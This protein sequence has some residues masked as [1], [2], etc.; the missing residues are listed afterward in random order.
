MV[1]EEKNKIQ[2][3]TESLRILA[4]GTVLRE[5]LE[6]ILRAKTGALIVVGDN[7]EVIDLVNGG[8]YINAELTSAHLYELAKM[9]GAIILSSDQRKILYANTQL[10]PDPSIPS[11]ETGIR[12]RIAQRV[13]TQTSNL[14]ISISQRR[15]IITLYKGT[16]KYILQDTN[17]VLNK[18]NQAIQ[19]LEKYKSVLDQAMTS[20]SALELE[21]LVTLYDVCLVIQRTEMVIRITSEIEKYIN[22]LGSEG[23]LVSMQLEE[24]ICFVKE[25]G[26]YVIEDYRIDSEEKSKESIINRLRELSSEELLDLTNIA[27][28]LGYSYDIN[29]LDI[30][31]MPRGYRILFKIPRLPGSVIKN[32]VDY[33]ANFQKILRAS[34]EELYDVE[35][36][37]EVRAKNIKDGL[38]R[39]RDQILLDRHLLKK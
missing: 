11:S 18:A 37:G 28:I 23:R 32:I 27:Q 30:P 13:A 7:P 6:N 1:K 35:G 25:D 31:V 24:L 21:D 26:G 38:R 15:N 12:H 4:P 16:D 8:F 5:G 36:I 9:D 39:V 14:V 19:T 17:K 22:E 2:D 3:I 20:L 10:N 29:I 34:I 33:F